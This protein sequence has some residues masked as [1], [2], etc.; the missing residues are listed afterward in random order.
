MFKKTPED[1]QKELERDETVIDWSKSK[2]I[3][4]AKKETIEKSLNTEELVQYL[5]VNIASNAKY[6]I[7]ALHS[8]CMQEN[9]HI[10]D[11]LVI[12]HFPSE[13]MG[14]EQ[15]FDFIVDEAKDNII[16]QLPYNEEL[17][18]AKRLLSQN[19][20]DLDDF[21]RDVIGTCYTKYCMD[22]TTV[23][24]NEEVFDIIKGKPA[25]PVGTVSG[26][27][28]K[29]ADGKWEAVQ[30]NHDFPLMGHDKHVQ[31]KTDAKKPEP[32]KEGK[33]MSGAE[34][35]EKLKQLKKDLASGKVK[36]AKIN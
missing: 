14:F 24:A 8:K 35:L 11:K 15:C 29:V 27:Y 26:S 1:V 18:N 20:V 5:I 12:S 6:A 33:K 36:T 17:L 21:I 22:M 3:E 13:N 25:V 28:K 31:E 2:T 16:T 30:N 19:E 7:R 4:V 23:K 10:S 34:M 9:G 32:K